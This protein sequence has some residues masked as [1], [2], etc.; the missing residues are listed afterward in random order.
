P[1]VRVVDDPKM[2]G[3]P[4]AIEAAGQ[5]LTFAGRIR[6]DLS[7]ANGLVMWIVAD[8]IRKGAASNAVQIAEILV[9]D[10]L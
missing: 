9:K 7:C 3:Y 10:Y 5:D 4:L 6:E 8:N 1:G 2:N